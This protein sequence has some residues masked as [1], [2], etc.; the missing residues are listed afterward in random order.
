MAHW[1]ILGAL[2]RRRSAPLLRYDAAV[3]ASMP[4]HLL[5]DIGVSR[6][7]VPSLARQVRQTRG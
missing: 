5:Y 4:D 3:L 7:G 2:R 6:D 1:S